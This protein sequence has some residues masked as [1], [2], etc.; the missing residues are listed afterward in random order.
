MAVKAESRAGLRPRDSKVVFVT[1]VFHVR[2]RMPKR[3]RAAG[4]GRG[5]MRASPRVIWRRMKL[6]EPAPLQA[7]LGSDP[8]ALEGPD[9]ACC[10]AAMM[11]A[12][13][14]EVKAGP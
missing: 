6:E 10:D 9:I 8:H 13:C 1:S 2:T 7:D 11:G 3:T 12:A 5:W 14:G 4:P